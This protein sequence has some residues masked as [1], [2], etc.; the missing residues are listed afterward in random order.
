[1]ICHS[2]RNKCYIVCQIYMTNDE[3]SVKT[4]INNQNKLFMISLK[5]NPTTMNNIVSQISR[6]YVVFVGYLEYKMQ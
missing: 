1:M 3:L 4:S 5:K 2:Y 6:R